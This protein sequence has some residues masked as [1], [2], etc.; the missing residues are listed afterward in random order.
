MRR[1]A[2]HQCGDRS[3]KI[4]LQN[5]ECGAG[6]GVVISPRDLGYDKAVEYAQAYHDNDAHVLI[7]SQ[8]YVPEFT[9]PK[10]ASYPTAKYRR[11]V[12]DPADLGNDLD[13]FS[14]INP[15]CV[16]GLRVTS[17]S[18]ILGR[19]VRFEELIPVLAGHFDRVMY[20]VPVAVP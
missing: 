3:Q 2:W 4:A 19:A 1:G 15:C 10:L 9:N 17:M 8:F 13:G 18:R 20:G 7:D 5:L 16:R 12:S 6:V 14:L 11:S